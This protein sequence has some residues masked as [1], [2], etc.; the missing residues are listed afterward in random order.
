MRKLIFFIVLLVMS[1]NAISQ[2]QD[3]TNPNTSKKSGIIDTGSHKH[4][5]PL[6]VVDGVILT[7]NRKKINP[8]DIL[9][10]TVINSPGSVKIY[11][12]QGANGVI[13]ISTRFQQN[14]YIR[15]PNDTVRKSG[16]PE[17]YRFKTAI[18]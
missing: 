9:N 8:D 3:T 18:I 11:G 2:S 5:E 7:G 14:I 6:Y 16:L 10:I 12:P 15:K 17:L 4:H 1:L 13:L